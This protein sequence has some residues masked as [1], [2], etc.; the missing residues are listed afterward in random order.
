MLPYELQIYSR[1]YGNWTGYYASACLMWLM[2]KARARQD[3]RIVDV[4]TG[5]VIYRGG[6]G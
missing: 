6:S 5:N 1:K 4:I 3:M 2:H